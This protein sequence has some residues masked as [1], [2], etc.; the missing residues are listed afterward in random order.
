MGNDEAR[1]KTDEEREAH[2]QAIRD[3]IKSLADKSR[4][5]SG[6]PTKN[7]IVN[8]WRPRGAINEGDDGAAGIA[9][10]KAE[11]AARESG[12]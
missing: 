5:P 10:V 12:S 9:A 4:F 2:V 1:F 6:D 11:L 7:E 3:K 8:G